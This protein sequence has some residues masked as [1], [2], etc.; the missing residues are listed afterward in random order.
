[1]SI[2]KKASIA[3]I[4]K[5]KTDKEEVLLFAGIIFFPEWAITLEFSYLFLV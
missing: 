5:D 4:N 1:M 3:N 2:E